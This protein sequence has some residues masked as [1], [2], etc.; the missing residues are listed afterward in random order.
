MYTFNYEFNLRIN[1]LSLI[2]MNFNS[3]NDFLIFLQDKINLYESSCVKT[4]TDMYDG[5]FY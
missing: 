2:K 5:N 4:I 1:N 3:S